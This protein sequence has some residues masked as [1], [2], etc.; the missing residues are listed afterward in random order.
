MTSGAKRRADKGARLHRTKGL[1]QSLCFMKRNI[2][3][4][5]EKRCNGCGLCVQGC[6]EGALQ[7]IDGKARMVSELY[8]DGLGACIGDCPQG[9]IRII[10]REAEAYDERA[11]MARIA[12]KG[13]ATILAHLKHLKDHGESGYLQQ[14]ID[15][16]RR[17]GIEV[18]SERL[19]GLVE[20]KPQGDSGCPAA[21]S[22]SS[23][24]DDT[25]A[26]KVAQAEDTLPTGNI[27]SS[28]CP[29]TVFRSFATRHTASQSETAGN[30]RPKANGVNGGEKTDRLNESGRLDAADETDNGSARRTEVSGSS[31]PGIASELTHWPIQLHLLNPHASC[32]R[33]A[34]VLIAADCTAFSFGDFHR[35]FLQGKKLAIACPKLDCNKDIYVEK[36]R[37]MID[38]AE[39][40]TLTVVIM[41]VPCCGGLVRIVRQ[42][43][44][45]AGRKVPL[46]QIVV[47]IQGEVL[48]QEWV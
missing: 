33:N 35:R 14:G 29:G 22:F 4:I 15:Y 47:G 24:G 23:A 44:Q 28:G 11:V 27:S 2:I 9:A 17:H 31:C 43:M 6:H 10:E 34:D 39:I 45:E 12:S 32:F 41:E 42:A 38:T 19:A 13:E 16:L 30:I 7:L 20:E 40:D 37:Q 1:M 48:R 36:I 21:G 5:D 46:K 18:D 8:C 26:G 3:E 25:A